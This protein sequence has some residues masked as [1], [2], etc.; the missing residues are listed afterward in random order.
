MTVETRKPMEKIVINHQRRNISL[1]TRITLATTITAVLASIAVG[2]FAFARNQA[3]QSFLGD[4]FQNATGERAQS[5][6]EALAA[7]EARKI[8]NF[9]ISIDIS[10]TSTAAYT[11]NLLSQKVPFADTTY[12]EANQRLTRISG[13]GWDNPNNDLASIYAPLTFQL[14]E[15]KVSIANTLSHLDFIVPDLVENDPN[16]IAMY[17]GNHDGYTYYYPNIDLATLVPPDFDPS[18]RSWFTKAENSLYKN[19]SVVWSE[20]YND[21]AQHGLVVTSSIPIYDEKENFYGVIGADVKL[22]SITSQVEHIQIG[23]TGYAFL[24]DNAGNII[25]MPDLGYTKFGIPPV[26]TSEGEEPQVTSLNQGPSYLQ[27]IFNGMARHVTGLARIK[28]QGVEHYL[29]F[30]PIISTGYSL[31]L[32]VPVNEMDIA[33]RNAQALVTEENQETQNY[34]LL[35]LAIV[36]IAATVI[37]FGSSQLLTIPLNQLTTT[38]K[39]VSAGDLTAQAPKSNVTEVSVLANAFNS[40]TSQLKETLAGLEEHV[41]E[42]TTEL[43]TANKQI[44]HRAS[45]FEA[46]AQVARSI[47][48]S[49]DLETLLPKITS[50]I[51]QHFGFY[52]V[53]I[54]LLD[55]DGEFAV[56]RAANSPGGKKMLE[57]AHQ[58]KVGETGIVGYVTSQ[59]RPRIALDTDVDTVFFNNPDLPDT[60]SEMALPL[61]IGNQVIGALDVQS[62]EPNAFSQ[63]DI[64]TLSTLADQ[65]SIAIQNAR[66]YEE[67]RRALAQYQTLY[68]QFTQSGWSQYKQS[69]K[70]TGIRRSKANTVFL[71]EP[72]EKDDFNGSNTLNLPINL[73][74]H[75]IGSLNVRAAD[76]HLWTQD[77]VDIALAIIERAALS[78]ENARLLDDAKRRATREQVI[79]EV[80]SKIS[81]A[82]NLDSVLQTALR[83]MGRILPGAEISIQVEND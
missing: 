47:S 58:L 50:V 73:R 72:L 55:V 16:I 18:K 30:T 32:V 42:R 80:S 9:F 45:Q 3:T 34:G 83:E 78:L 12:W 13:G 38:A 51:S 60:R 6:I 62:L 76:N 31:A 64:S 49:Q 48:S 41:A 21:A 22:E 1:R 40:M 53:G 8:N 36:V 46:I 54:F 65:V 82:I 75:K 19:S 29:A 70:L 52:H 59:G 28:L 66:L 71:K 10:V 24:S 79:G 7:D 14:T 44:H 68:Q 33:F 69:H 17:F 15:D 77:E 43:E 2:Y 11:A 81:S 74:S 25:A 39:L 35:L 5:Q 61:T 56:L 4:Q 37:S 63:E 57:R 27:P 67:T 26:K 20:P 23:E